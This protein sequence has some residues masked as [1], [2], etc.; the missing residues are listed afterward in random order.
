MV[1]YFIQAGETAIKIGVTDNI[2]NRLTNLN[3]GNHEPLNLLWQ[4]DCPSR[5]KAEETEQSLHSF[6]KDYHIKG[7]W[8]KNSPFIHFCIGILKVGGYSSLCDYVN[9][10]MYFEV[11]NK[12]SL[13]LQGIRVV[14]REY[15]DKYNYHALRIILT[16][17]DGLK[18]D[19]KLGH[20]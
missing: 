8:F 5:N 12:L 17:L 9:E 13:R 2:E 3:T 15:A 4:I 7:E 18:E 14:A 19:I 16:E 11:F 20:C 6:F 1:V 10:G